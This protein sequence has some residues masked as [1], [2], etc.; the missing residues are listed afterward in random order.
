MDTACVCVNLE[1]KN[2]YKLPNTK[3]KSNATKVRP[4]IEVF[5]IFIRPYA[6]NCK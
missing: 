5:Y 6:I 4:R 1:N 2:I 3:F